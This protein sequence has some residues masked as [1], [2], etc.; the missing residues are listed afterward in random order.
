MPVRVLHLD[1]GREWRGGQRQL[2]LLADGQRA[3]GLEPLVAAP[4]QAALVTHCRSRGVAV[5]A[6]P[7]RSRLDLFAVR[8]ISALVRTW[9]PDILHAHDARSL[10]LAR[11]VHLLHPGVPLVATRR[12]AERVRHPSTYRRG[13]ARVIAISESVVSA[14]RAAHIPAAHI[15][16]VYP[17]V[18]TPHVTTPRDWRTE[19]GWQPDDLIVGVVLTGDSRA[20][21]AIAAALP[22]VPA[23]SR[24]RLRFV[25]LGGPS[26]GLSTL[27]DLPVLRAGIVHEVH[28]ALAGFDL[29]LQPVAGEGLGT[30]IVEALALERPVILAHDGSLAELVED[31]VSG[32]YEPPSD[33]TALA[34]ALTR[35]A[36]QTDQRVRLGRAGPTRA[37]RFAVEAMVDGIDAV[38]AE[39]RRTTHPQ[40]GI[41]Q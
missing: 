33:P 14:L 32:V 40:G 24:A 9:R 19:C 11:V 27:A 17:G 23:A 35:L 38:Y 10:A 8:R 2:L 28:A 25:I 6:I 21:D 31:D 29:L 20:P 22:F 41:S 15:R 16:L 5:A 7:M 36:S 26:T 39:L 1:S 3:A 4:P 34:A 30:T 12:S 37:A 18:A 13:V